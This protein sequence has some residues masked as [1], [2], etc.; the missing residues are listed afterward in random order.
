MAEE[1]KDMRNRTVATRRAF[2]KG[3]LLASAPLLAGSATPEAAMNAKGEMRFSEKDDRDAHNVRD[4]LLPVPDAQSL[5][6]IFGK[7]E[8]NRASEKLPAAVQAARGE[9][10]WVRATP[11]FSPN[12]GPSTF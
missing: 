5:A 7:T 6:R 12:S 11:S 1:L 10:S 3:T 8:I 9:H 2:L 4:H